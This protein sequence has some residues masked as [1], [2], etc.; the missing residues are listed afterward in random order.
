M[1]GNKTNTDYNRIHSHTLVQRV[2]PRLGNQSPKNAFP[3]ENVLPQTKP[4]ESGEK[5]NQDEA[6]ASRTG[7]A[8]DVQWRN[9][10][11]PDIGQ[12]ISAMQLTNSGTEKETLQTLNQQKNNKKQEDGT[13][14]Q[15]SPTEQKVGVSSQELAVSQLKKS[16]KMEL[17]KG[18]KYEAHLHDKEHL[19][20]QTLSYFQA[21]FTALQKEDVLVGVQEL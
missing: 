9:G 4:N 15:S 2:S 7:T 3:S 16:G 18:D 20:M 10:H 14:K 17:R 8:I 19:L 21:L 12:A 6:I 13:K 1:S 11:L 5:Y